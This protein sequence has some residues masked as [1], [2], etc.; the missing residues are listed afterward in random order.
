MLIY[1]EYND[2]NTDTH[3]YQGSCIYSTDPVSCG[4]TLGTPCIQEDMPI[5]P[6]TPRTTINTH[7]PVVY[8]L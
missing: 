6:P 2:R 4:Y 3:P 7:Y 1:R 8:R 5:K